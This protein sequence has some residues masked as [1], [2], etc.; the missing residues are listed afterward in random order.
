MLKIN[1]DIFVTGKLIFLKHLLGTNILKIM[2]K[3][4]YLH[5]NYVI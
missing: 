2:S 1:K 3:L 5:F 4:I